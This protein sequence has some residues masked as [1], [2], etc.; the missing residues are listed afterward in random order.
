MQW[1]QQIQNRPEFTENRSDIFF[2]K[3]FKEVSFLDFYSR[4]CC[5]KPPSNSWGRVLQMQRLPVAF[6]LSWFFKVS[7]V[8]LVAFELLSWFERRTS[9]PGRFQTN[10]HQAIGMKWLGWTKYSKDLLVFGLV[11]AKS[12]RKELRKEPNGLSCNASDFQQ[13]NVCFSI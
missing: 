11:K 6:L 9:R 3:K 8:F 13:L 4:F 5:E 12:A 7:L 2:S 10:Q 1:I